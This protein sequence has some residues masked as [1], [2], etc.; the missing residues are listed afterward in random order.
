MEQL[1]LVFSLLKKNI[2]YILQSAIFKSF[3]IARLPV[4]V[5]HSIPDLELIIRI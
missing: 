4:R 5:T 3:G 2:I 1:R